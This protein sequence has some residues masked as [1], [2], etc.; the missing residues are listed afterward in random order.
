MI[1]AGI[2]IMGEPADLEGK[3]AV[4]LPLR[5]EDGMAS[6]GSIKLGMTPALF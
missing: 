2:N 3:R 6:L 1:T 5:F 4:T